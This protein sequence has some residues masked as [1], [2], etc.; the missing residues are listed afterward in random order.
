[1]L[2]RRRSVF[3]SLLAAVSIVLLGCGD[4]APNVTP[5]RG[6]LYHKSQP[7]AGALVIFTPVNE[8]DPSAWP[9]GYP[10]ATV[11]SDGSF[12]AGTFSATDGAPDGEYILTVT[13]MQPAPGANAEDPEAETFDRLGG[14][15]FDP[16]KSKLKATVSA[17]ATDL[18]RFELQ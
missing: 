13:W 14:R 17:P 18:G 4:G 7:A 6:E 3:V 5:V 10:R 15:Y 2:F 16:R 12:Q 8:G 1:M 9:N 11:N